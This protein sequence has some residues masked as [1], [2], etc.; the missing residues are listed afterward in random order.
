MEV[1]EHR[2]SENTGAPRASA[3]QR[4]LLRLEDGLHRPGVA[5]AILLGS[6]LLTALA[7]AVTRHFAIEDARQQFE[8]RAD[9]VHHRI[10]RRMVSYETMLRGGAALFAASVDVSRAEWKRYVDTVEPERHY[11]GLQGFGVTRLLAPGEVAGFEQGVR[12]EGFPSFTVRPA[13]ARELMSAIVYLEPFNARNQRAFGFDMLSEPTRRAAMLRAR[14]T[15]SVAMSGIVTLVQED[16]RDVQKGF[17]L[18]L[19]VL[20]Q[21]PS[22]TPG[23]ALTAAAD[24]GP[25][26]A[27][28]PALWGWVYAPFRVRDLMT[29]ILGNDTGALAFRIH[30]DTPTAPAEAF[31]ASWSAG[32]MAASAASVAARGP[33]QFELQRPL[34]FGGRR[35]VVHYEGRDVAGMVDTWQSNL[36][37]L[38]GLSI[39]LLLFWSLASLARRKNQFEHEV[40]ARSAESR[41]RL[42]WLT[43]VSA[44]SPDAVLVFER[45][46]SDGAHRLVFTNPAFSQWFGLRPEDLL[47]L[48]EDAVDEWLSGLAPDGAEPMAPLA[49]GEARVAL[50]GPPPRQLQRGMREGE[51]QRVYYFRDVTHESEVDRLKNEFLTTAAHELRTPLASVYG[52]S[53]LLANAP[54]DERQR[55]RA[56]EV[57]FRQ[58]GVLKHLVDELLDLARIDSRQGQDFSHEPV[59][60]QAVALS[61]C[62]C[63]LRPGETPRVQV[64]PGGAPVWTLGDAGKLQQ[65]VVNVL[66]NGLKYSQPPAPVTLSVLSATHEARDWA[67][68]RIVDT[69]IGMSPE[70][71]AQAFDRFYRADPS[72]H[73]LGAGLGLAIVKEIVS[74]H[75]GR[76]TLDSTPGAGTQVTIWLPRAAAPVAGPAPEPPAEASPGDGAN[77]AASPAPATAG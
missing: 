45:D 67:L 56:A 48:T 39:D 12:A 22:G 75:Q 29:G 9:E 32:T 43:A 21:A 31:Y 70:Q 38:C 59:D 47:G 74:L 14:D 55:K 34:D 37:A 65:A 10:E 23:A 60:L 51:H 16:G 15:G 26:G 7:W 30:D 71:C 50:A 40:V 24:A 36:V 46:A 73:I 66:A 3:W 33:A 76:V 1:I 8:R 17:L 4:W 58:A 13:G 18:Y 19:P 57:V 72:G 27:V 62:E 42:A 52:F 68:L 28:R 11:P 35:W 49:R 53:E 20:R 77:Q 6:L 5:L 44:L 63:L 54:I 41:A 64:L 61:A 25:R 2:P 69:G